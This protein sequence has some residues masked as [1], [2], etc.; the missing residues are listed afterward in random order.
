LLYKGSSQFEIT[1]KDF[2]NNNSIFNFSALIN[3]TLYYSNATTGVLITPFN[4][5]SN[6]LFNI[7]INSSDYFSQTIEHNISS[8]LLAYLPQSIINFTGKNILGNLV[9]DWSLF[10]GSKLILN[11]SSSSGIAFLS[12]GNYSNVR[13]KSNNNIF[14]EQ[15]LESFEIKSLDNK[16][17]NLTI[18]TFNLNITAKNLITS[19]DINNFSI[20]VTDLI[21]DD[22][23]EFSTTTGS[24]YLGVINSTYNIS[25]N[26]LGYSMQD[27]SII[28][29]MSS[30]YNHTF[31]LFTTNSINF[32]FRK[33]SD[34]SLIT[35]LLYV[36][37]IGSL[38]NYNFS[39]STGKLY[40]DL[41]S[42][43]YYTI[44]Y[45]GEGY[46]QRN[47]YFTLLN[48]SYN[49][50]T[51]YLSSTPL[52]NITFRVYDE[53]NNK[54]EGV[55]IRAL[56]YDSVS[57]SYI[58]TNMG[59]TNFEGES[60]LQLRKSDVFYKFALYYNNELKT[61][62]EPTYI[63]TDLLVFNIII[64]SVPVFDSSL[65]IQHD[66]VFN[67]LTNNCRF[68]FVN[69]LGLTNEFCLSSYRISSL[70]STLL[71]T[72]CVS[73]SAGSIL[74]Y[75]PP[76][77][78]S[79]IQCKSYYVLEGETKG[80][81]QIFH[82]FLKEVQEQN[83]WLFLFLILMFVFCMIGVWNIKLAVI[84]TPIP[85]F[86]GSILGVINIS[87]AIS[88]SLIILGIILGVVLK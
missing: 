38:L 66:L 78:G 3:G 87:P 54:V 11:T 30:S 14:A 39:T 48:R 61:F 86:L 67:T 80:L 37:L 23:R 51:L 47:Y 8:D 22:E 58:L 81:K 65:N 27:S 35:S 36:D 49:E 43:Q 34:N 24:I 71:N 84:L 73:S 59:K 2:F 63:Y 50:I 26:A 9:E 7:S 75:V 56:K 57:N 28:L 17:I 62:T 76:I 5:S 16:T 33:E 68:D 88:G 29:N 1:A 72:S 46:Q 4:T 74:L 82:T 70:S 21:N 15:N 32:S 69:S 60:V 41:L 42:P 64:G 53:V 19:N 55:E 45:G 52:S 79:T 85:L 6:F 83:I 10:N 25:I 44:Q 40:V 18:F 13:I 20:K 12:A 31:Y 77:N